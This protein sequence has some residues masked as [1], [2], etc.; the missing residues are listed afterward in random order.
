[1]IEDTVWLQKWVVGFNRN[2]PELNRESLANGEECYQIP[3][4]RVVNSVKFDGLD[5]VKSDKT[6]N[7][8]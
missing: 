3:E 4:K 5:L 7:F 1:M 8:G 6:G 2:R